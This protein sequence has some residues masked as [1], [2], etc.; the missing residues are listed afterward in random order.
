VCVC[1]FIVH[2]SIAKGWKVQRL[3][4]SL[5]FSC[6]VYFNLLFFQKWNRSLCLL[7]ETYPN[8]TPKFYF[9]PYREQIVS[10]VKTKV[11][12]L[13]VASNRCLLSAAYRIHINTQ[14]LLSAAYRMHINTRCLLSAA[15]RMHISTRCLLSAA[16]RMHISTR[17]LLSAAYRMHISTQ[18]LLSAA[19]RMHIKTQY[20]DMQSISV[21]H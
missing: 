14:C 11:L 9:V 1:L 5:C 20:T 15:Y 3:N 17:C 8:C 6:T 21:L 10:N 19:Y 13:A 12:M 2:T 18:C 7:S 4:I 16:Y